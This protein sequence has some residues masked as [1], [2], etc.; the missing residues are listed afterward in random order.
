MLDKS[1]PTVY[2]MVIEEKDIDRGY[3]SRTDYYVVLNHRGEELKMEVS[4]ETFGAHEVGDK[5][6]VMLYDGAFDKP[7]FII[8]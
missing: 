3:K 5:L 2:E 6:P 7:Y 8:E 1:E 4:N